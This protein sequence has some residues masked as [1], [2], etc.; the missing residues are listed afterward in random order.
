M[1][2]CRASLVDSTSQASRWSALATIL[3][4]WKA[5]TGLF[6]C[7]KDP[8]VIGSLTTGDASLMSG[9]RVGRW[10]APVPKLRQPAGICPTPRPANRRPFSAT[11]ERDLV[12]RAVLA[13][14]DVLCAFL[15]GEPPSRGKGV[16]L[17][18]VR[19]ADFAA[20]AV[21]RVDPPPAPTRRV[22][23]GP[24]SHDRPNDVV[25][26]LVCSQRQDF[27]NITSERSRLLC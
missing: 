3:I 26:L 6:A 11:R 20:R 13:V 19:P 4:S 15:A 21:T 2:S 24:L 12:D 16:C 8:G 7:H 14:T 25:T 27:Q 18:V 22:D 9:P 1:R 23:S 5:E 10:S 17:R